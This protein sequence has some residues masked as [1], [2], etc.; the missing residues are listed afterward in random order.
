MSEAVL[1]LDSGAEDS[2]PDTG[3][4]SEQP[5]NEVELFADDTPTSARD[6][7]DGNSNGETSDF[8][9]EQHDWLR[10]DTEAV[11]EQYRGLVPLAKNLQAQF[12]R[13]QQDLAEQRREL[14]AQ[15]GEWANRVQQVAVP[16][17]PQ[18][19]PIQEMRNNL[20]D[21][22]ARGIDAVEQIIQHRV[23]TQMQQMQNQVAQ[24]QQQLSH[25]NQYVQGQQTAYIDSQVQEARGEYGQDLDNYTD[26]IVA[27][28]RI[29]NPQTGQP[30]TVREAYELHAGITAQKAAE[31]RQN[32]SQARKSSKRAVRSSSGVDASEETGPMSDNEVLSGLAN[33]GFD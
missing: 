9:P 32:D 19:D 27:T 18:I 30:Y 5:T 17:Q 33:L 3:S 20:S 11:P 14:Q 16:Q 1:D 15:Q 26:Q 13:T 12:T 6:N 8:D 21:E 4:S 29:N 28:V 7:G 24:L 31:L 25:A 10:G 2:S 23:G 22:D